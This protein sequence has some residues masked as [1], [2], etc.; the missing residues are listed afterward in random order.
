MK[1]LLPI[2]CLV[3]LVSCSNEPEVLTGPLLTKDGITYDQKTNKIITGYTN[4]LYNNGQLK[5]K[6]NYINGL[7]T[8]SFE[9]FYDNGQLQSKGTYFYGIKNGLWENYHDNGQLHK[10]GHFINNKRDG[11]TESFLE[12][13]ELSY[14]ENYIDGEMFDDVVSINNENG[15][16]KTKYYERNGQTVLTT[17]FFYNNG[18]LK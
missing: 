17:H 18:Q 8:G 6:G 13:G 7:K 14:V 3:L 10:R 9:S 16:P 5:E 2:L 4:T 15:Q 11:P 12:N 1:K